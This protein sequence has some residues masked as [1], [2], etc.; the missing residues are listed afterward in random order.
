MDKQKVLELAE[1]VERMYIDVADQ[2]LVNICR[3]FKDGMDLP[4]AQWQIRKL[5]EMGRLNDESIRIIAYYA[6]RTPAEIADGIKAA[7]TLGVEGT[8]RTLQAAAAAGA[9]QTATTT[10]ETSARVQEMTAAYVGQ[11]I[12]KANLVNT[13]MLQSTQTRYAQAVQQ[14]AALE[15]AKIETALTA[16]TAGEV[17]AK[18]GVAQEVL[19]TGAGELVLGGWSR[20][21]AVAK[22]IEQLSAK[23]IYGFVD[24]AGREWTPEAYVNMDIG[25]TFHNVSREAR[26]ARAADYGVDTFQIST[27]AGARPLCAPYQGWVCSWSGGGYEIEDLN[28]KR[29]L[30]HNINETSYG[31]PAG[32]FGINCGHEAITFVPGFSL[33]RYDE[34]NADELKKNDETYR[35]SQEQRAEER[36]V[37][38]LNREAA[39]LKAAGLDYAEIEGKA[40][41]ALKDYRAWCKDHGRT[42]RIDR[43][44]IYSKLKETKGGS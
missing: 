9:I 1:P 36:K 24:R 29:Y 38:A 18:L 6:K 31:E 2:L 39:G 14:V 3:H 35:I 40:A 8:E 37:R 25:T 30:V 32:I 28:G 21:D 12:D 42:P 7:A 19:N 34:L 13:V 15:L 16:A 33:A 26:K 27:H 23:G 22:A 10:I 5:S 11:A 44:K 4:L 41:A 17:A 43:T 20:R